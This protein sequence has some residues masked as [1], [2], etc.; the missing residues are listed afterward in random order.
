MKF[1]LGILAFTLLLTGA[2]VL[3]DAQALT[4]SEALLSAGYSDATPRVHLTHVNWSVFDSSAF[5][6]TPIG[7]SHYQWDTQYV[8]QNNTPTDD[9]LKAW[10]ELISPIPQSVQE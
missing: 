6:V 4:P 5:N 8:V 7:P 9:A 2:C 1:V 3:L 10:N